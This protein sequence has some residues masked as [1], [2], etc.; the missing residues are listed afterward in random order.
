MGRAIGG[1][2]RSSLLR[3]A[4]RA[5]RTARKLTASM[6]KAAEMS[7]APIV[8]PAT[9]GPSTRAALNIAELRATALPMSS[10]PTISTANAWRVGMSTTL[11]RPPSRARTMT[12]HT[13]TSAVATRANIVNARIIL[14]AWVAISALRLGTASA[15]RPP[16]RP[17]TMTGIHCIAA[18]TPEQERVTGELEDQP[19]LGDRLHPGADERHELAAEVEAVVAVAERARAVG[20]RQ[21][22]PGADHRFGSGR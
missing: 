1:A 5:S 18:T 13:S 14:T 2:V 17:R 21:P 3:I 12:C 9:A 8:S 6:K 15:I 10:R 19:A 16:N 7:N 22:R 11:V 20:E 4:S